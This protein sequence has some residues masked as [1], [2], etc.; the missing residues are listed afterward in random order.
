MNKANQKNKKYLPYDPERLDALVTSEYGMTKVYIRMCLK[1][2]NKSLT[3]DKV[4][5]DY[6]SLKN[7]FFG[8]SGKIQQQKLKTMKTKIIHHVRTKT[9][10]DEVT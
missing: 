10:L 6:K 3:A 8:S 2:D 1:G 5:A 4:Q 9:S 7:R